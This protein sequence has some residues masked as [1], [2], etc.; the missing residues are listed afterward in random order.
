ADT[1]LAAAAPS[2]EASVARSLLALSRGRA[3]EALMMLEA[4]EAS[5]VTLAEGARARA[6][7][8]G[9]MGRFQEA[10]AAAGQAWGFRPQGARHACLLAHAAALAGDTASAEATLRGIVDAEAR[11]CARVVRSELALARGDLTVADSE[12]SVVLGALA[13]RATNDEEAWAHHLRGRAAQARAD[14]ASAGAEHRAAAQ[15]AP[16][17]DETLLLGALEGLV[18]AGDGASARTLS[19]RLTPEAPSPQRRAETLVEI[20]LDQRDFAGA[21][22]ALRVLPPGARTE[23]SRGRVLEA[24]GDTQGALMRY[25]AA[26]VDA[27]LAVEAALRRAHLLSRLGRDAE[28]RQALE[29]GARSAPTDPGVASA[30]AHAALATDDVAAARQALGGALGAHPTDARLLVLSALLRARD[31]NPSS[32]LQAAQQA[33]AT[34]PE[35]AELQLDLA[36]VARLAGDRAVETQA[37]ASALRIEPQRFAATMCVV[38]TTLEAGDLPRATQ[39]LEQAR[40]AGA[41]EPQLSR[42]RAELAVAA[43]HGQLDVDTV[44]GFLR[45][46]RNDVPLLVAL[47]RLQLQAEAGNDADDTA[48]RI[49][50]ISPEHPEALYVRAYVAYVDGHFSTAAELLDRSG[51]AATASSLRARVHALRGMLAFEE[52]RYGNPQ[53]LADQAIALDPRCATAHLLKALIAGSSHRDAQRAELEAATQGTDTPAEAVARLAMALGP[54]TAGCALAERYVRMAPDGYDRRDVDD[55]RARCR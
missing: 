40:S 23:L 6:L 10:Q 16:P 42:M 25:T 46:Q 12:A 39:L 18:R 22:A 31:G 55:V 19:A 32:A 15:L 20:A 9:A 41:P 14:A 30:L 43:G 36:E 51:R 37:C 2:P 47:A 33:A 5:G 26:S 44:Q 11:P 38:R 8:L 1:L 4:L 34:A 13:E 7:A 50:S 49:L 21:D 53:A 54:D 35:D 3:T 17:A 45:T 24:Q 29:L 52:G 27:S 28:A 48:R